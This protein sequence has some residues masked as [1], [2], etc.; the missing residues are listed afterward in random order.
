[1]EDAELLDYTGFICRKLCN[2]LSVSKSI[3]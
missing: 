2:E 1:L 3:V